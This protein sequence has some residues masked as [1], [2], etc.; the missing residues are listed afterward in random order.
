MHTPAARR[1]RW[2]LLGELCYH[3][4]LGH[5]VRMVFGGG[6]VG[7]ES[8]QEESA[9]SRKRHVKGGPR[10]AL[11]ITQNEMD[12]S[13]FGANNRLSILMEGNK[14]DHLPTVLGKVLN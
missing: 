13:V 9:A 14:V 2:A 10:L 12:Y 5:C 6:G 1:A 3:V 8:R 7:A 11:R 4:S